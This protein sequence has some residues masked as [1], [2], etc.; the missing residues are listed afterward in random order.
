[1]VLVEFWFEQIIH[2]RYFVEKCGYL[3]RD[4][5]LESRKKLLLIL[6]IIT[7]LFLTL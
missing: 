4:R 1:M 5:V 6:L 7:I 2:M 3:N